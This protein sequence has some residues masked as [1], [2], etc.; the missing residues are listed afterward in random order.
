MATYTTY[1]GLAKPAGTDRVDIEVLNEN[2]DKIDAGLRENSDT[3]AGKQDK[4]TFDNKPIENSTNPA[5]SGGIFA[6]LEQVKE[7]VS[8]GLAEKVDKDS[9]QS[10]PVENST[11]PISAGAVFDAL[12]QVQDSLVFDDVP[13]AGSE[14]PVKSGG[15]KAALDEKQSL[16]NMVPEVEDV[17]DGDYIFLERNGEIFKCLAEKI[18]L[19]GDLL[20]TEAGEILT[21]ESGENLLFDLAT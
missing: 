21:T 3:T 16:L 9:V 10:A 4:L 17:I 2:F 7:T 8:D 20:K 14:N 19:I 1:Y 15:I 11:D 18:L 13:V 12:Q 6:A 5:T